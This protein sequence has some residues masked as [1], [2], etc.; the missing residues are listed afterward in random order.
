MNNPKNPK[1]RNLI[2]GA[3]RRVFSR[4]ELRNKAIEKSLVKD[5][6]DPQR[7]RVTKWC[8]CPKCGKMEARYKMQVDHER[9]VVPV[10][11]SLEEMNWD[12]VIDRLW[13]DEENL[14][15]MCIP[16]HALKTKEESKER[17]RLKKEGKK[18]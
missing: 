2:K 11:R 16:C 18:K 6:Y 13:C 12:E 1:E 7:P 5:Y 3:I 17:R 15:P 14:I 8:Q 10:G 9:P 4:S